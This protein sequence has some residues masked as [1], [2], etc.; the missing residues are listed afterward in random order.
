M[1]A[2]SD[3]EYPR[4]FNSGRAWAEASDD[5]G[6][7]ENIETFTYDAGTSF[8]E[9]LALYKRCIDPEGNLVEDDILDGFEADGHMLTS[10]YLFGFI[11]GVQAA[12]TAAKGQPEND[13]GV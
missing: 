9:L 11:D 3:E 5:Q 2:D 10:E 1:T 7:I 8:D 6:A 13:R 4:G 12:I